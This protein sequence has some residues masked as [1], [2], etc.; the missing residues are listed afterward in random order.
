MGKRINIH[1]IIL[2][3]L[4]WSGV[5]IAQDIYTVERVPF[6]SK[7]YDEYVPVIYNDGLVF[8]ANKRMD[9]FVRFDDPQGNPAMNIF[10][11]RKTGEN[12][13]SDPVLFSPDLRSI[14]QHSGP[15]TFNSRGNRIYF[16]RNYDG[17]G[18]NADSKVGIF[19][20][21]LV[22]GE[23]TGIQP[24]IH[25][26]PAVN[27]LH[28]SL[29]EDGNSL[30]FASDRAGG[31]GGMDIYVCRL[32]GSAWSEPVNLGPNINTRRHDIYPVIH[33][34]GRLYFSSNEL[35]GIGGYDIFYTEYID[36]QWVDP[37]HLDPPFNSRRHDACFV[38]L[39]TSYTA[40][41]I[42]SNRDRSRDNG[43]FAFK[44]SVPEFE[45]C[46]LMEENSYC[47]TFFE[48]G[49]MVIDTTNFMYEWLIEG[50]KF[51]RDEVDYCFQGPGLYSIQL[52]VV[53]MLSGSVLFN[54]ASYEL[55]IEDVEQVYIS[56]PDTVIAG[57]VVNLSGSRTFLKDFEIEHFY[58]DMGDHNWKYDS[59][60]TYSYHKPGTYTLR[61]GVTS[62]ADD[63]ENVK[64]ACSFRRIRVIPRSE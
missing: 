49:T 17:S 38:A 11:S 22:N 46:R 36:G 16:N 33:P 45:E 42:T 23:W 5:A 3:A 62:K 13:W 25:N 27:L 19:Y 52:N 35:P 55:D 48:S 63:P 14:T 44:L 58:W 18:K 29:S 2:L 41:Y 4:S 15:V 24:F 54:Q 1:I 6:S 10:I 56:V 34:N 20:A 51:R 53:D 43:I 60:I 9:A 31:F 39:D 30:F 12:E 61:L 8:T 40:G 57:E 50:K 64:E 21:G 32:E 37:V 59:T 7:A 28:P 26:D 47:F